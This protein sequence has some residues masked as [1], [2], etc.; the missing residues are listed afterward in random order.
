MS[1][2]QSRH[3]SQDSPGS[4]NWTP[5]GRRGKKK[6]KKTISDFGWEHGKV[7]MGRKRTEANMFKYTVQNSQRLKSLKNKAQKY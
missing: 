6:K 1:K 2:C 7:V 4:T 3:C 5:S